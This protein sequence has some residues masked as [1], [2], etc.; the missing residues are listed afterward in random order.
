MR[1]NHT[2]RGVSVSVSDAWKAKMPRR[3]SLFWDVDPM[4]VD[5]EKNARYVI[6]RILDYGE[7]DEIRWMWGAYPRDVIK[8]VLGLPRCVVHD[9]SR[10]FWE[11]L[12]A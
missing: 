8:H 4:D 12:L 7:E 10:T 3:R 5:P 9:K 6:E 11:L 2:V 1:Y